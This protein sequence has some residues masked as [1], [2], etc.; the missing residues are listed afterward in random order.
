[1][2]TSEGAGGQYPLG[3]HDDGT[4]RTP[5]G[6]PLSDLRLDGLR[7]GEL[8]TAD[9][10]IHAGTL[11]RQAEI[12]Q[13]AGFPQLAANLRRAAELTRV[14]HETVLAVYEALRPYRVTHE[15]LLALA[16]EL[17]ETYGATENAALIRE[18]AQAYKE[19][20]LL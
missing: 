7:A 19:Q 18:A 11:N 6:R 8:G 9:L 14:P 3:E 13:E 5:T 15:R 20:G 16:D 17:E 4:I 1:M 12:A 10:G 2:S